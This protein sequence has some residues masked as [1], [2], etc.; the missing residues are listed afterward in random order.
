MLTKHIEDNIKEVQDILNQKNDGVEAT[1]AVAQSVISSVQATFN[2]YQGTQSVDERLKFLAQGLQEV[3]S[4]VENSHN[5][6]E[7]DV[8]DCRLQIQTLE[9]LLHK[10]KNFEKEAGEQTVS[11][12]EEGEKKGTGFK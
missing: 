7:K 8:L 3:V 11:I 12:E 2:S 9:T 1:K 5:S 10:V 4:I 6:L